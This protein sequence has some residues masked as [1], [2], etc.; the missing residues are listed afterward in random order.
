MIKHITRVI[1]EFIYAIV[2]YCII[3][4]LSFIIPKKKNLIIFIGGEDGR[5][6]DNAKYL[7]L[8]L[9]NLKA[10]GLE[11]YFLTRDKGTYKKLR[12]RSLPVLYYPRFRTS[13]LL[14]RADILIVDNWVW[15]ED[16]K[17]FYLLR[18]N[19]G[20]VLGSRIYV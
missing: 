13:V 20:T 8:Y 6:L 4:P 16:N 7:F 1:K 3:I 10:S 2:G 17:Y 5:F 19:Y 18:T 9:H 11:Y 14:L 15:I 12:L